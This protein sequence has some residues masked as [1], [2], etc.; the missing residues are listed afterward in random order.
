MKLIK[1]KFVNSTVLSFLLICAFWM[2]AFASTGNDTLPRYLQKKID[3]Y[4]TLAAIYQKNNNHNKAA[5][6]FNKIAYIYWENKYS[7]KAIEYF[8]QSLESNNKIGNKNA[9]WAINNNIGMIYS[10]L[11]QYEKSLEALNN[12]LR[13]SKEM[14]KKEK[15]ASTLNNI[16][17]IQRYL[18][19]EEEAIKTLQKAL[20]LAHELNNLRLIR[21]C[22]AALSEIYKKLGNS[23][24]S[25]ENFELYSTFDKKIKQIEMEQV[26]MES[27]AKVAKANAEKRAKEL[28]LK[29]QSARLKAAKDSI[30]KIELLTRE[31]EQ[32]IILL[33]KQREIE[34]QESKLKT[35]K[36]IRN[37]IAVGFVIVLLFSILLIIQYKQKHKAYKQIE[38]QNIELQEQKEI[39]QDNN[40]QLE[41][42]NKLITDSIQYASKIQEAILPSKI[43]IRENFP[44]S[45][46]YYRPKD[47]VS[48]DFYWF[49]HQGD[50]IFIAAVDCTGHSVPGAFMSMIGNTLL[51][52]IVNEKKILTPSEILTNLNTGIIKALNQREA[53]DSQDGMD[54]SLCRINRK[55]NKIEFSAASHSIYLIKNNELKVY[56]GDIFSIGGVFSQRSDLK[57][58]NY[59]I[60]IEEDTLLYIFSDGYQDQFGGKNNKKFMAENFKKTL[61]HHHKQP[62]R[63]QE[64]MLS[65]TFENW[66]DNNKQ[67]DDILVIGLKI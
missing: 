35:A 44:E 21:S 66:R 61:F 64:L 23:E 36:T 19:K 55:E 57:F 10:D 14:E 63:E 46:I 17:L 45:F 43:A 54:I 28:E 39:I 60:P 27:M 31:R 16:S 42:K 65:E 2:S 51:N 22:Y 53:G 18:N 34:E 38:R 6:Y 9:I 1:M 24:K 29:L 56:E 11:G 40:V 8:R 50:N 48:G 37:I 62:L 20:Q 12:S 25:A 33:K 49:S 13:V 32:E 3:N 52:E 26:R 41:K 67:T 58:T 15:I 4:E 5:L 47:I 7:Q 59:S 30:E